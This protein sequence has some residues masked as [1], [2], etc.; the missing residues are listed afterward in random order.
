LFH[1]FVQT[2]VQTDP[3]LFADIVDHVENVVCEGTWKVMGWWKAA[4]TDETAT[5][6]ARVHIVHIEKNGQ[7][8]MWSP[9]APTVVA[10]TDTVPEQPAGPPRVVGHSLN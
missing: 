2:A 8:R 7:I 10:E 4:T 1:C 5:F 9:T 3:Q 6:F